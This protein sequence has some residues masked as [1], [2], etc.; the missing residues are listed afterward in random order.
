MESYFNGHHY[1][2]KNIAI[3]IQNLKN[4]GQEITPPF[5]HNMSQVKCYEQL[6]GDIPKN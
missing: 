4:R 6:N 2:I 5:Y 1:G 3:T